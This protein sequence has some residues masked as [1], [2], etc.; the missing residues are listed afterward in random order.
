MNFR[1][2]SI[3]CIDDGAFPVGAARSVNRLLLVL[4]RRLPPLLSFAIFS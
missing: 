1:S 4:G 2:S 3:P